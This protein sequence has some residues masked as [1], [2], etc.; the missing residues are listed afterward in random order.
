MSPREKTYLIAVSSRTIFWLLMAAISIMS[1]ASCRPTY[2]ADI[3]QRQ[4]LFNSGKTRWYLEPATST[5]AKYRREPF[6]QEKRK[7]KK[8]IR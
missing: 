7:R 4:F 1:L 8:K 2:H 3:K 5:Q 6:M